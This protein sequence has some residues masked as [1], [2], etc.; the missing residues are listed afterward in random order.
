MIVC[1][2][3]LKGDASAKRLQN[4]CKETQHKAENDRL[5]TSQEDAAQHN[6]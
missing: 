4:K 2:L 5:Q 1:R 6:L 3:S